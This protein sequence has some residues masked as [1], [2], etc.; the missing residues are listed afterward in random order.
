MA[1]V[2]ETVLQRAGFSVEVAKD[3]STARHV[4][5]EARHDLILLDMMLPDGSGLEVLRDIQD[6]GR[7]CQVI[8]I[9]ANGSINLAVEAMR[10][11]A[12][13]FLV[14]PFD[15]RRLLGA[16]E[17]AATKL[18]AGE[19]GSVRSSEPAAS[20]ALPVASDELQPFAGFLGSSDAMRQVFRT[21]R[22][23]G[24]SNA[25]VFLQG[26]SGTG[27]ELAAQAIHMIS[28]RRSG[29]FVPINCGAIPG[30]LL[31]SEM[32][33]HMRGAFTGAIADK[34]GAAAAA[35]GG[36]LFLDEV[37]EMPFAL[38]TKLL[39]FLQTSTI[40]PVGATQAHAVDVRIVC[41]TNRDPVAEVRAG[42]FREDLYYRLHVVPVPLP[43]LRERGGDVV[44]I[45]EHL[46]RVYAEA[47]RSSFRGLSAEAMAL[48]RRY[49]WP[50]NVREL[51]NVLRSIMVLYDAPLI[52]PEMLPP[53]IRN[54]RSAPTT[55]APTADPAVHHAANSVRA[56]QDERSHLRAL[57]G[58]S[59]TD[60]EDAFIV[61]TISHCGGS[62]PKAARLL[63]VSPSTL[64]RRRQ[65]SGE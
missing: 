60:L 37:C 36:T 48:L 12:S 11:G 28:P 14:K 54:G 24:R 1:L 20:C 18:R 44:E 64:Y 47:E 53:H 23:V 62:I 61:E 2:Y 9:T 43:P 59:L 45:A 22:S 33:G 42:R 40:Q 3:V 5:K 38:Q 51:Q 21:I 31:E 10:S 63:G 7:N 19:A 6:S 35:D 39:R 17:T 27:K 4:W 15:D 65:P 25:A 58:M 30:E 55:M 57:V 32:F 56:D 50:G 8:V 16:I 52:L 29:P 49:D 26:E 46:I 13:D 41:A 34:R